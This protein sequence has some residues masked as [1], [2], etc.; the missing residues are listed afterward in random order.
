MQKTIDELIVV[1]RED[2]LKR[3]I[4]TEIMTINK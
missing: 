3:T 1:H 4:A 2:V